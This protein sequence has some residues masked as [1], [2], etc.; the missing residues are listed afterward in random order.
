MHRETR[1][2]G[3]VIKADGRALLQLDTFGSDDREQPGKISQ[4]LQ[5]TRASASQFI[6]MAFDAF[7]DLRKQQ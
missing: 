4:S 7:P 6:H 3:F 5:F 2:H 1:C